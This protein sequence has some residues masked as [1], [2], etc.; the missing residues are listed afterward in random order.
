MGSRGRQ[1]RVLG[2][3]SINKAE[4]AK[5]K[6]QG[7]R[8]DVGVVIQ[9]NNNV[10]TRCQRG[11]YSRKKLGVKECTWI[12]GIMAFGHK[13]GKMLVPDRANSRKIPAG[14]VG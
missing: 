5:F 6:G 10:V 14:A 1:P 12:G 2:K 3:D 13:V 8:L 11:L 4:G 9:A 7:T